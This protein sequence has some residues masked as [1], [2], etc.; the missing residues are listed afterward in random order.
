M[1]WA[2]Q[3]DMV[4]HN[5][6]RHPSVTGKQAHPQT[7]RRGN[8]CDMES[9]RHLGTRDAARNY[10]RTG[11]IPV[12]AGATPRRG[13]SLRHG[14]IHRRPME[15]FHEQGGSSRTALCCR[16][17]RYR[18]SGRG[19]RRNWCFAGRSGK[20]SGYSKMKAELDDVRRDGLGAARSAAQ[21]PRAGCRGSASP[22]TSCRRCST[23]QSRCRRR[24]PAR[25]MEK[26]KAEALATWAVAL[27]KSCGR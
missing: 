22:T 19:R 13:A 3:E 12:G 16:R 11:E 20:L 26:Q 18:W 8:C 14:D 27:A 25:R 17:W 1:K 4:P 15:A 2:A 6:V 24:V 5:F 23:M 7:D 9:L 21:S 10:G